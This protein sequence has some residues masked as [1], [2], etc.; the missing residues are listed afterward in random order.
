MIQ[1]IIYSDPFTAASLDAITL[2]HDGDDSNVLDIA[3]M[4]KV[5]ILPPS[6]PAELPALA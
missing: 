2:G 1:T 5:M 4:R 3:Y 6:L